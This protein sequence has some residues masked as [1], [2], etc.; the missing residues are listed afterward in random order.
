MCFCS[1]YRKW[2]AGSPHS[3][4]CSTYRAKCVDALARTGGKP[5][6]DFC[7]AHPDRVLSRLHFFDAAYAR[8]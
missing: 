2:R 4:P 7:A 5:P 1:A 6:I 3:I 8:S